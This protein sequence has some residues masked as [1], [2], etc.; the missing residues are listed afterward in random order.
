MRR[1]EALARDDDDMREL[2]IAYIALCAQT[3]RIQLWFN[4]I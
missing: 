4:F 1:A 2:C 3:I